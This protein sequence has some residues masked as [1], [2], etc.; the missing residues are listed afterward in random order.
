M[1]MT[2]GRS[3]EEIEEGMQND[4]ENAEGKKRGKR[5]T[6][7]QSLSFFPNRLSFGS[8]RLP[9]LSGDLTGRRR[10]S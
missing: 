1:S 5:D 9:S 6:D 10:N 4:R 7:T 8:A 3:V 2:I